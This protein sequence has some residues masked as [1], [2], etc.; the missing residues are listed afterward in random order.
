M[1]HCSPKV[2]AARQVRD[3]RR[4][5][6]LMRNAAFLA[7]S[8]CLAAPALAAPAAVAPAGELQSFRAVYD[9]SLERAGGDVI[10]AGGRIVIEFIGNS[11]DGFTTNLRQLT[12]LAGEVGETVIDTTVSTFEDPERDQFSFRVRTVMPMAET[13][14]VEG[15]AEKADGTMGIAL[16]APET[17]ELEKAETPDFPVQHILA[18]IAAARSG[19]PT[20]SQ[21]FYDGGDD[22]RD[23]FDTFAVIGREVTPDPDSLIPEEARTRAWRV[24]LSYFER[25]EGGEATPFYIAGFDLYENGLTDR[26]RLDFIDFVLRGTMTEFTLLDG[27]TCP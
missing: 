23:I 7:A 12:T 17:V 9:L 13:I 6:A 24:A 27:G 5:E 10:G 18:M 11:C 8:L 25:G 26:L 14:H 22:G 15:M 4:S 19:E 1:R 21:A 20:L 16:T 3:N 2:R